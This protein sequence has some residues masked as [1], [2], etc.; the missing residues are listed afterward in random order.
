MRTTTFRSDVRLPIAVLLILIGFAAAPAAAQDV[1]TPPIPALLEPT[2]L[3]STGRIVDADQHRGDA[4]IVGTTRE[5]AI[6]DQSLTTPDL[7]FVPREL[8]GRL[9]VP[10]DLV[11]F[12]RIERVVLDPWSGERLGRLLSPTGIGTVESLAADVARVRI[13]H[14]FLPILIGDYARPVEE[15]D[16]LASWTSATARAGSHVEGPVVAF[17]DDKAI[18]P[19]FDRIFLRTSETHALV[20]GEVVLVDRP[21]AV[22]DGRQLP[23]VAIGRAMVV[24][25]EG[26]VATA[27]LYE[28]YRSDLVPGDRFRREGT[29][30]E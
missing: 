1:V 28:T 23:D 3:L 11:Q 13:T 16:T 18:V 10:G 14:A 7:V 8:R 9:L 30:A 12:Y 4:A 21:G 6:R 15:P 24:L 2:F 22:V 27:V 25:V 17:Q 20:P 26:R 19:P 5:L 29:A